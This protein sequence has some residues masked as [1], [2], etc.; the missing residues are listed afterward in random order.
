MLE[1]GPLTIHLYALCILTG[2]IFAVWLGRVRY[3]KVGGNPE[4]ISEAATWA[5]PAGIIGGRLYHVI[6][7]PEKYFGK[8]GTSTDAFKIWEGGLGIW[9]AISLGAFAAF[10]FYRRHKTSLSFPYFLDAVAPGIAIAQAIGRVGNWFNVELF[11]S[12]TTLPWALSVPKF[13]RP[14]GYLD[15]ETYHPTFLYELIWCSVIAFL[16][17]KLPGKIKGLIKNPGDL[18]ALYVAFYTAGRLWIEALRIDEANHIFGLRLNIWVSL[19]VLSGSVIY[20]AKSRAKSEN[21][22]AAS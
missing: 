9:G 21:G 1:I 6:T 14:F 18:F 5:I 15:F 20:L 7:S 3:K 22:S 12:P 16:L 19:L 11:G 17:I 10:L 2:I 8:N 4:D 13:D